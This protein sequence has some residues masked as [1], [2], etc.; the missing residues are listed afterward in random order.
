MPYP[1]LDAATVRLSAPRR[2]TQEVSRYVYEQS[3]AEGARR[4]A[5]ITYLSKLG[6]EFRNW[7]LF[8]PAGEEIPLTEEAAPLPI[9]ADD[10]ELN[11]AL[12]LLGVR[13][14]GR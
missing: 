10:P 13:L 7:A 12:E 3:T 6:D 14:V 2:F 11:R 1:H 4:F 8:E 5:G 9:E